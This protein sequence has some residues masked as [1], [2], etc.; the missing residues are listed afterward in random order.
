MR[1]YGLL[2]TGVF[3]ILAVVLVSAC[4][5]GAADS[6]PTPSPANNF[7]SQLVAASCPTP[8]HCIAVGW[9]RDPGNHRYTA[10]I[11]ETTGDG[12]SIVSSP[13]WPDGQGSL[14]EDVTCADQVHCLAV[15]LTL[16]SASVPSTLIEASS[17]SGWSVIPSPNATDSSGHSSGRLHGVA[18]ST[19][20][21]CIA[22]GASQSGPSSNALIEEN[23]GLG[24]SISSNPDGH[25]ANT[26][27]SSVACEGPDRCVA[28]GW[29]GYRPLLEDWSGEGWSL[30]PE[31]QDVAAGPLEH[32]TCA[33]SAY[34]VAVGVLVVPLCCVTTGLIENA[35]SGWQSKRGPDSGFGSSYL[36]GA[37][38]LSPTECTA[39]GNEAVPVGHV[40]AT[41]TLIW[42]K[43]G[44][45]WNKIPRLADNGHW[46]ALRGVACASDHHCVIVGY[47]RESATSDAT[48][49]IAESSPTGWRVLSS[50]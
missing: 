41:G 14:L 50:S 21:H 11:E 29:F 17:G 19:P 43:T 34:C 18:C 3:L 28:V 24:W 6:N 4:D 2:S 47:Q 38:C 31:G 42:Q 1:R 20:T 32:V 10:L 25:T 49:L 12:W 27:L 45:S 48:T 35:G 13:T 9:T 23:S 44:D 46:L 15:G 39:V 30:D 5:S 33:R 8:A 22:V 40:Q 16:D 36:T 26:S 7:G 37:A